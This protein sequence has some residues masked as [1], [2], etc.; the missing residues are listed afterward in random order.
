MFEYFVLGVTVGYLLFPLSELIGSI[1]TRM[2]DGR[3]CS[4]SC[5]QGRR[6][7]DCGRA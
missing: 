4:G 6:P 2:I 5:Q 1:V 3:G 7:C